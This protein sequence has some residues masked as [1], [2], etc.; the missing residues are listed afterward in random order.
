MDILHQSKMELNFAAIGGDDYSSQLSPAWRRQATTCTF[1]IVLLLSFAIGLVTVLVTALLW[2]L[3]LVMEM[4]VS[5]HS[6]MVE[7]PLI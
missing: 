5:A 3:E 7:C 4:T 2:H 1:V 6:S